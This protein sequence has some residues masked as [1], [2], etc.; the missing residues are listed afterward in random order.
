MS[1]LA[2]F[3][4][5]IATVALLSTPVWGQ[6]VTLASLEG[7]TVEAAATFQQ[8]IVV[9][10]QPISQEMHVNAQV[11]FGSEG[12]LN[13]QFQNTVVGPMG[14]RAGPTRS[15]NRTIGRP[16]KDT[17]GNDTVWI[18]AD[19]TLT[20]LRV[21]HEGGAG[22][23]ILRIAFSRSAD[24]LHCSFSGAIA[25]ESGVADVRTDSLIINNL[26]VQIIS[27]KQVSSTCHV[28]K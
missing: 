1:L 16:G 3:S 2:K 11:R 24:R 9:K 14:T 12:A 4:F 22:G 17:Q 10:G 28:T 6:A 27:N 25:H 8:R 15:A 19:G 23:Q 5:G 21:H 13:V 18:F 26:P 20:R 7:A